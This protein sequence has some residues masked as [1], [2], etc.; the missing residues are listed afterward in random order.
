MLFESVTKKPF[1]IAAF[2]FI[3]SACSTFV[4]II[5][6]KKKSC[7]ISAGCDELRH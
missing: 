3:V 1:K 2:K 6:F 7:S 5:K 4:F